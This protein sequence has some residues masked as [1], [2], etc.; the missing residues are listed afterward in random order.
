MTSG[1]RWLSRLRE[2]FTARAVERD[3]NEELQSHIDHLADDY[4]RRG[5]PR[6][7][8]RRLAVRDFGGAGGVDVT[9]ESI[10]D[11]RGL[12]LLEQ[13]G[14][15]ARRAIRSL[16]KTRGFTAVAILT[17]SLGIGV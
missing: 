3:L 9:R 5:V 8:A 15:D 14:I 12:P 16:A 4:I 1:R 13:L 7:D 11:L 17:L 6:D 10:R 2:F